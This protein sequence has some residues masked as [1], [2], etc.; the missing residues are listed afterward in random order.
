MFFPGIYNGTVW[1]NLIFNI[2]VDLNTLSPCVTNDWVTIENICF[3][4]KAS[5][6]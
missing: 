3:F 2:H 4:F 1:K 6:S 5:S